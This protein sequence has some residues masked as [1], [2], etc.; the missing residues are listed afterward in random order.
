MDIII[1]FL[2]F[3]QFCKNRNLDHKCGTRSDWL[4]RRYWIQTD[5]ISLFIDC[6]PYADSGKLVITKLYKFTP[7][8]YNLL[9][10]E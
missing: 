2:D 3:L 9:N 4:L 10:K 5:K 7:S 6:S 8:L 1:F